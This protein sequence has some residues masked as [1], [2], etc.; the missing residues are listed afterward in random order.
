MKNRNNNLRRVL[1]MVLMLLLTTELWTGLVVYASETAVSGTCGEEG[2]ENSIVWTLSYDGSLEINGSGKMENYGANDKGLFGGYS[3]APWYEYREKIKRITIGSGVSTIGAR[4]FDECNVENVVIP[5]SVTEIGEFAF[6]QCGKLKECRIPYGITSIKK[7]TFN[8]CK[9]LERVFIPDSVTRIEDSAFK[10]CSSLI[11][12]VIP[13]NVNYIGAESFRWCENIQSINIPYGVNG[14][15]EW[16]FSGCKA[17]S[18]INIPDS[19]LYIDNNAFWGCDNLVNIFLPNSIIAFGSSAF[20]D[21]VGLKSIVIPNQVEEISAYM[22]AGC[23]NLR[24]VTIP[25]SVTQI[26]YAAFSG[27]DKLSDIYYESSKEKWDWYFAKAGISSKVTVHYNCAYQNE[28]SDTPTG[29]SGL[30]QPQQNTQENEQTI[31]EYIYDSADPAKD[32]VLNTVLMNTVTDVESAVTAVQ[33]Q[34]RMMS[35][36]QKEAPTGIDLVTLYAETAAAKAASK[37]VTGNNILINKATV[38]E[39][40][41]LAKQSTEAVE[42]ALVAGGVSTARYLAKTVTLATQES[43]EISIRIDPDILTA[44]VDKIVIEAPTYVLTFKVVDLRDDLTEILTFTAQD[45]GS[46]FAPGDGSEKKT[47]KVNLP[48]SKTTNPITLSLPE[49]GGETT[50]QAIVNTNGESTSSKYNPARATMDGKI[51]SSGSYTV[52]T[53]QKDFSDI[54]NKSAEMQN[55]IR[56]LASKGIIGG[57]GDGK[58]TPDGSITRAEIA[59]LM[60]RALGKLDNSAKPTFTDVTTANW[61]YAT[62]A[63][64]QKAKLINGYEDNTFRGGNQINKE[65][66]VAVSARVLKNEMGYKEPSNP[67]SYLSKYSDSVV[68]WARPEVALATKENMVVYR[69]DG[70]FNG[71]KSMTRGDAAIIIY[72]MF[73][74]IW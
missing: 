3:Y 17:L 25:M 44:D 13:S 57:T 73:Q 5:D 8:S 30:A 68:E 10:S 49:S 38:T 11:D 70:T 1:S 58:F 24:S 9:N 14:I 59:A 32:M 56:Y 37:A 45:V 2:N 43:G 33:N 64:S 71:S 12:I 62:A 22:L 51:S 63:S 72:R 54:A 26:S 19:V 28:R 40:T 74:R 7:Y 39:L 41:E 60:V 42:S 52:Q 23:K 31:P 4:A 53:N 34:T 48:N 29:N 27:C 16:T 67:A 66:I 35:T 65:Q 6:M 50:Y 15:N 55:A 46:G 18:N 36:A 61:Y 20:H 21:C 69:T 47:V